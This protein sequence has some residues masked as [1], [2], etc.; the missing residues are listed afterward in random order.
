MSYIGTYKLGKLCLGDTPIAK[1][2][3]GD[4][5]IFSGDGSSVP[6]LPYDTEI[7]Y[8]QSSGTQYIDTGISLTTDF[9]CEIK[10]ELITHTNTFE[11][12]LGSLDNGVYG[13]ALGFLKSGGYPYIE[14][15]VRNTS[16]TVSPLSLR[17]YK[18][19]LK[20]GVLTMNA[21]G[22]STTT[23]HSG[24]LP[25]KS[26]YLFCR[27]NGNSASNFV[28]AKVYYCKIWNGGNLVFDA[29]PV[30]VGQVGQLY[31]RISGQ[32]FG[33]A[34]SGSFTLGNDKQ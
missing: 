10:A 1:A 8:L 30:R 9:K 31:D 27:H 13:T 11:T 20:N 22:T 16:V 14:F 2:Y 15:G 24:G 26:L 34:G 6:S 33:N 25:N 7:E 23:S 18:S 29:I 4:D 21:D 3:L 28:S 5:L 19:S 12:L 17:V 32:L